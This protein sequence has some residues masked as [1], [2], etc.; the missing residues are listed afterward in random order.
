MTPQER[1]E[2]EELK[3]MV[4][5]LHGVTDVPFIE[6]A[7]RRIVNPRITDL[8]LE[9]TISKET[10]GNTTGV[11]KS[12]NEAGASSYSVADSY[13]GT[14]IINDREGNSYKLGYYTV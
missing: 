1:Q 8:E 7:K 12:V 10:T 6:N 9:T 5:D 14:I 2:F 13:D 3:R 4:R 11:H